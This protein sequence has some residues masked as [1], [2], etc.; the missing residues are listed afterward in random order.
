MRSCLR[1]PRRCRRGCRPPGAASSPFSSLGSGSRIGLRPA[2]LERDRVGVVG[3]VDARLIGGIRLRHLLGAVAQRHHARRRALDQRL[4][5]REERVAEA[6]RADRVGEV[7][8][9][10]LRDV[11]RQLEML[12]LVLADR[13]VGGAIDQ[14]VGRHQGRIGVEPDRGVLAVLAGLLLE[15]GHAVEPAEARDAVEHPG[16]L[17]V[18]GDL[19]LVEDDVLLRIDA[20]GDEGRGHFA[21]RARQLGRVLPDRD[22]VQIDHAID[23]VVALLQLDELDDRAEIIAEMQVAGRLHAGKHT[24]LERHGGD[25][26]RCAS[27]ATTPR[28]AQGR[29]TGRACERADARVAAALDAASGGASN[30]TCRRDCVRGIAPL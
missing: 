14:D 22:G 1:A 25:P 9:E 10:L 30:C 27:H 19:A 24:L 28:A 26:R 17:G 15:L 29:A 4:G 3:E 23:A 8:V 5:Q 7:V 18:L 12:L 16:E 2:D 21:D 13:H 11:A 6:V 20:A